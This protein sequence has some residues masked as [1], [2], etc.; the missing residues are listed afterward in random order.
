MSEV[1]GA[2]G[3]EPNLEGH[4]ELC[5]LLS[6]KVNIAKLATSQRLSDLEVREL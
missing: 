1:S 4:D 3:F 2:E 6:R 5:V